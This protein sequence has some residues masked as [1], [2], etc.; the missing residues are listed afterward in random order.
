MELFEVIAYGVLFGLNVLFGWLG[1]KWVTKKGYPELGWVIWLCCIVAGF[2]VP[3]LVVSFLPGRA[4]R[5]PRRRLKRGPG[6]LAP[7]RMPEPR[8]PAGQ[9]E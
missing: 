6:H 7:A 1:S 5:V 9:A 2:V 4:H 3:L 8:K